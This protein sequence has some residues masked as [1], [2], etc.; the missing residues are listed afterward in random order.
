MPSAVELECVFQEVVS[1]LCVYR[2]FH[3]QTPDLVTEEMTALAGCVPVC[4]SC[5]CFCGCH[6]NTV[7]SL[8]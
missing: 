7:F 4:E 5:R 8:C 1:A 6:D 2:R 3:Q